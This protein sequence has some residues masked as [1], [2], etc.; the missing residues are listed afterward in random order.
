[1]PTRI[2]LAPAKGRFALFRQYVPLAIVTL[3]V[4]MIA[5]QVAGFL[6]TSKQQQALIA[7]RNDTREM[8][9]VQQAIVDKKVA[10]EDY[11]LTGNLD[12]LRGFVMAAQTL[13]QEQALIRRLVAQREGGLRLSAPA[14][15]DR[16]DAIWERTIRFALSGN[17][18]QAQAILL[19][20][21]TTQLI[22]AVRS[23]IS[24]FL[25]QRNAYSDV[26][27]ARIATGR[28]AV[29]SLQIV[30]GVLTLLCLISA[31]RL[32][33][34]EA[35]RRR[36]AMS[37]ALEAH[38]RVKILFE[39]ADVLQSASG[40]EDAK[41]VLRSSASRLLP[42]LNGRLYVFNNSRDR[43]DLLTE[44]N[45]EDT[46]VTSINP[47][48]CWALKR[49]K[50]HVNSSDPLA[51]KC[52]HYDCHRPTLEVPMMARGELYGLLTFAPITDDMTD[53]S[54]GGLVSALADGMSLA[55]S[56]IALREKLKNQALRD[57]LTGL[58]NRRYMEDML[59][60]FV[61]LSARTATPV[62]VVMLDLDHFKRL[63]DEHGHLL[64]DTVLRAVG[65]VLKEGLRET[66]VACRYGGEELIVL[67]PDCGLEDAMAKAESL[68]ARV[69]SLSEIH[70][71]RITASFGVA[72][73]PDSAVLARD[74]IASAD[75]ALYDS[76]R[77]GRNRVTAAAT[78]LKEPKALAAE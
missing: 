4:V 23:D 77:S 51:L 73:A 27:E 46:S 25:V 14:S 16:L 15:F 20:Q 55:L 63:N 5:T 22:S 21:K 78:R 66:D 60:R 69:E 38:S 43:L 33:G 70:G 41:A 64:G 10:A 19:D 44:W 6:Y 68:R 75:A 71:V 24:K 39:M 65:Q 47:G 45:G 42:G 12:H 72:A 35:A 54:E 57:P 74:L 28:S 13:Q 11:L 48:D 9:I 31:F 62:S 40:Y 3:V 52:T 67:L 7:L 18:S 50:N 56:N 8:R 30:G 76:K 61:L 34:S 37:E 49:G 53:I 59:E 1:M 36:A 17:K 32:S 2:V 29:L 58:Y 26:L